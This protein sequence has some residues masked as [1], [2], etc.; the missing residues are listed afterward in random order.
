MNLAEAVTYLKKVF[1]IS[2]EK[3]ADY[4]G[5][6][7]TEVTKI[8]QGYKNIYAS[9]LQKI[10]NAMRISMDELMEN[11][12]LPPSYHFSKHIYSTFVESKK[13]YD[14]FFIKKGDKLYIRPFVYEPFKEGQL[15]LVWQNGDYH[16][17][18]FKGNPET[19][20]KEGKMVHFHIVGQSRILYQPLDDIEYQQKLDAEKER[21]SRK[22][23]RPIKL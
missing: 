20:L 5:I 14:Q 17:E 13:N 12:F 22:R 16:V 10:S 23:G 3:A 8:L 19:Y 9:T 21:Q 6:S 15:V 18:K 7:R 11:K 4:L 2:N 1:N